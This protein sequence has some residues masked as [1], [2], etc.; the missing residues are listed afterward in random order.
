M[1]AGR[2]CSLHHG[3]GQATC[4]GRSAP[5][6]EVPWISVPAACTAGQRTACLVVVGCS[7]YTTP[8]GLPNPA[9]PVM[10]HALPPLPQVRRPPWPTSS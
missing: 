10:P 5:P 4:T 7:P 2:S 1:F 3:S 9:P 6:A 8:A